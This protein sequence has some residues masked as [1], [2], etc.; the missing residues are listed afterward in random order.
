MSPADERTAGVRRILLALD[1]SPDSRAA[2]DVVARLAALLEAELRGLY[3]EDQTL[4]SLPDV[5]LIREV[6]AVSGR[7]RQIRDAGLEGQLR[8]E[9]TRAGR[10]LARVGEQMGIRWSF[11]VSRGK[12][13]AEVAA[14]ARENDL[15]TVGVRSRRAGGGPGSTARALLRA[16]GQPV[17][18]I[19]EGMRLG[20]RVH[21]LDDGSDGAG[22]A[23]AVA[24]AISRHPRATLTIDVAGEGEEQEARIRGHR[25]RLAREGGARPRRHPPRRRGGVRAPGPPPEQGRGRRAGAGRAPAPGELPRPGGRLSRAQPSSSKA[26]SPT[27]WPPGDSKKISSAP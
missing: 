8:A 15:V 7:I 23:V 27:M 25:E 16:A 19:R 3:V 14:A 11:R 10:E 24:E 20:D 22:Q 1:A 17:L 12:V 13:A 21:V 9:A 26:A 4:T 6:D 2:L 5:S 18:I